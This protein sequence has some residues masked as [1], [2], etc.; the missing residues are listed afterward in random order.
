MHLNFVQNVMTAQRLYMDN[1]V[2][3]ILFVFKFGYEGEV[4]VESILAPLGFSSD[5]E[6]KLYPIRN[7]V[8]HYPID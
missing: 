6:P 1:T 7:F 4:K 3:T 2:R 5:S 8:F